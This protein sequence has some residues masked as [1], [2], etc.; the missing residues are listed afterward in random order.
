MAWISSFPL[1][2]AESSWFTLA[3]DQ[4]WRSQSTAPLDV[5][6]SQGQSGLF[7]AAPAFVSPAA[8]SEHKT[9]LGQW[10]GQ[11]GWLRFAPWGRQHVNEQPLGG[12]KESYLSA[13]PGRA[14][15]GHLW[16][17]L[18]QSSGT[19]TVPACTSEVPWLPQNSPEPSWCRS[20][21]LKGDL[22]RRVRGMWA[23]QNRSIWGDGDVPGDVMQPP[24][25]PR[26]LHTHGEWY[27]TRSAA[28]QGL[29]CSSRKVKSTAN[30]LCA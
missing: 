9:L 26:S 27:H 30:L 18:F 7:S 2:P 4:Q 1:M 13:V 17:T 19:W 11:I 8:R 15:R 29:L 24:A 16:L 10:G 14:E 21:W 28:I 23:T 22:L 25:A 12:E 5:R 20:H 6:L 3:E